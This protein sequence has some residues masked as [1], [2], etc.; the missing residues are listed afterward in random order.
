MPSLP[1]LIVLSDCKQRDY[2]VQL[3]IL[4]GTASDLSITLDLGLDPVAPRIADMAPLSYRADRLS[5]RRGL[6]DVLLNRVSRAPLTMHATT[7][8]MQLREMTMR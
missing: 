8:R 5:L 2:S 4:Y 7:R 3:A 6:L 1:L